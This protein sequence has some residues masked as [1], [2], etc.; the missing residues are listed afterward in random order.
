MIIADSPLRL[1]YAGENIMNLTDLIRHAQPDEENLRDK[2]LET[3]TLADTITALLSGM[4]EGDRAEVLANL[5]LA[6]G[7]AVEEGKT[8]QLLNTI[9]EGVEMAFLRT[10]AYADMLTTFRLRELGRLHP[11]QADLFEMIARAA[12]SDEKLSAEVEASDSQDDDLSDRI[13]ALQLEITRAITLEPESL[14]L[15]SKLERMLTAAG[16]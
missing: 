9:D 8:R 3:H 16:K 11:R 5:L 2:I 4:P 6:I 7:E 14:E 13:R 10:A 1:S 15:E 12:H